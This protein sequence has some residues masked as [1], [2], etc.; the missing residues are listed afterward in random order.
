MSQWLS[1]GSVPAPAHKSHNDSDSLFHVSFSLHVHLVY[2]KTVY[3]FIQPNMHQ[4]VQIRQEYVY[5]GSINEV[6]NGPVFDND[7]IF[8]VSSL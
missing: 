3:L 8:N 5:I 2:N 1:K 7:A 6:S 4:P